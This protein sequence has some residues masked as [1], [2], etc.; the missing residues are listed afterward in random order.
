MD[1]LF[2]KH[3]INIDNKIKATA[4]YDKLVKQITN[5]KLDYGD[6]N[7]ENKLCDF[8]LECI[9]DER[10]SLHKILFLIEKFGL[11]F[12]LFVN[13]I[14]NNKCG[15]NVKSKCKLMIQQS[16]A[17]MNGLREKNS[18]VTTDDD[19][20]QDNRIFNIN[21]N[22][23]DDW[24]H[25]ILKQLLALPNSTKRKNDDNNDDVTTN[26][27]NNNKNTSLFENIDKWNDDSLKINQLSNIDISD[28]NLFEYSQS[29][30][31]IEKQT[32]IL[33]RDYYEYATKANKMAFE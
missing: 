28:L 3:N 13:T 24:K 19:M 15:N 10:M 1:Q 12:E 16:I 7:D 6:I 8:Y 18:L 30:K 22:G 31:L 20:K 23:N 33:K 27:D 25:D 17:I 5:N 9:N 2:G 4:A 26:D 29:L 21:Y 32:N 11:S 14:K